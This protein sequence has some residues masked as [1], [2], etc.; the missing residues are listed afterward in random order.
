[1]SNITNDIQAAQQKLNE[2]KRLQELETQQKLRLEQERQALDSEFQAEKLEAEQMELFIK[3]KLEYLDTL[4]DFSQYEKQREDLEQQLRSVA[5]KEHE[6]LQLLE[7]CILQIA[8]TI[9]RKLSKGWTRSP[10]EFR[11]YLVTETSRVVGYSQAFVS[12]ILFR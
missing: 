10:T 5:A 3:G 11:G 1:M 4:R 2:L 6:Q 7:N 8:S 9:Q 12:R